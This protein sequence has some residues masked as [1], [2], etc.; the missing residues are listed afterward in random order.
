M[1]ED[2]DGELAQAQFAGGQHSA[3]PGDDH[4]VRRRQDRMNKSKFRDGRRHLGNLGISMDA[5][6]SG[7]WGKLFDRPALDVLHHDLGTC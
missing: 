5:G 6:V 3:V 4:S 7:V 2:H 1:F